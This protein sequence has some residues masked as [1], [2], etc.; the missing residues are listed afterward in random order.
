[1]FGNERARLE[2]MLQDIYAR[3]NI[4]MPAGS[5]RDSIADERED[6]TAETTIQFD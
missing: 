4:T 2:A 6:T 1:M 5:S 3:N